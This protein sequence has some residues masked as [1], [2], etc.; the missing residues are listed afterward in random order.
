[1]FDSWVDCVAGI[2]ESS[3]SG[4]RVRFW[5]PL[6]LAVAA[7]F[8]FY[9]S[10][11]ATQTHFDYTY[12]IATALL[13][14]HVGLLDQPPSWLNEMIPWEG[15]YYSVFPLGAVLA[16]IPVVLL[17]KVGLIHEFPVLGLAA[18]IAGACVYFF[19]SGCPAS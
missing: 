17:R 16:L 1:M 11:K 14:G 18:V 15:E 8:A 12:R 5:I 9:F 10:T 2:N 3:A 7:A 19:S 4:N 6:V 13:R